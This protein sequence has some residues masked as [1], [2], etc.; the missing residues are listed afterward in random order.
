MMFTWIGAAVEIPY[1]VHKLLGNLGPKLYFFRLP[2]VEESE[3]VYF[4]KRKDNFKLKKDEI[5]QA[6]Y[7]YLQYFDLNPSI[8][9]EQEDEVTRSIWRNENGN[10][11]SSSNGNDDPLPPKIE[12]YEDL[13]DETAERIIIRLALMLAHL[14]AIVPTWETYGSQG[15]DYNFAMP[16]IEDPSRAMTQMRNFAKGHALSQG[17]LSFTMED[18][19]FIIQTVMSTASTERVTIFN[20]LLAYNG[21]LGTD[22]ICESLEVS[23]PTALRTMTELKVA[24]LVDIPYRDKPNI[25]KEIKLKSKFDWFLTDEFADLS[26]GDE[27]RVR[28]WM[29]KE[30]YPPRTQ[31]GEKQKEGQPSDN[32]QD[33]EPETM[34]SEDV[35]GGEI[36]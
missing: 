21:T 32:T 4:G 1:K 35:R 11:N 3:D 30:K 36:S 25:E 31:D 34:E 29:R 6:L 18:I 8:V 2:R 12:M 22:K 17:R 14:R 7:E 5:K 16:K 33:T 28:K 26:S 20:L 24:G 10:G 19:P 9:I 13:H 23:K 15:S 27:E